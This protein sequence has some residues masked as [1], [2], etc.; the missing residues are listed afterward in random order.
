MS[1]WFASSSLWGNSHAMLIIPKIKAFDTI[2]PGWNS[3]AEKLLN[4]VKQT[5]YQDIGVNI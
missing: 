3:I 5:F 4:G 2:E 1:Y